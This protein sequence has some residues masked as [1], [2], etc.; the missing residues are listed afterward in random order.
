MASTPS[1]IA[2]ISITL[3]H[4]SAKSKQEGFASRLSS[5]LLSQSFHLWK[6]K[7]IGRPPQRAELPLSFTEIRKATLSFK[8]D[9]HSGYGTRLDPSQAILINDKPVP[10]LDLPQ[11]P[12]SKSLEFV[13]RKDV[14]VTG[15]LRTG[16]HGEKNVIEVNYLLSP[17]AIMRTQIPSQTIGSLTLDVKVFYPGIKEIIVKPPNYKHCMWDG[18][19]IPRDSV[20][21]PFCAKMPPPGGTNPKK[22][23]NCNHLLPPQAEFCEECGHKQPT[24]QKGAK[25]CIQC[26]KSL[27]ADALFCDKCGTKQP[28]YKEFR[29]EKAFC[30]RCGNQLAAD[31]EFCSKCGAQQPTSR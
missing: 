19:S 14:D 24:E 28:E 31:A 30:V 16:P 18:K 9:M 1:E 10:N 21:C 25:A 12:K 7:R 23:P 26:Q 22:C 17:A 20:V 4:A 3:I 11:N 13:E 15:L 29:E 2:V 6:E 27:S 8:F 5:E